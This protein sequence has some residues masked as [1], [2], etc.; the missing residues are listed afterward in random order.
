MKFLQTVACVLALDCVVVYLFENAF[1]AV[2][3]V[4]A[5]G[6]SSVALGWLAAAACFGV[7][8]VLLRFLRAGRVGVGKSAAPLLAFIVYFLIKLSVDAVDPDDIVSYTLSTSGGVIF[9]YLLGVIGAICMQGILELSP[10]HL[11]TRLFVNLGLFSFVCLFVVLLGVGYQDTASNLQ[12]AHLLVS[13][14]SGYQRSGNFLSMLFLLESLAVVG[15]VFINKRHGRLE[16]RIL[17]LSAIVAYV[18]T[19]PLIMYEGQLLGS[20]S[21]VLFVIATC[22]P[23]VAFVFFGLRGRDEEGKRMTLFKVAVIGI[24]AICALTLLAWGAVSYFDIDVTNLRL[25]NFGEGGAAPT[26]VSTRLAIL[27]S[28]YL[29]QLNYSPIF[30]NMAVDTLT[31]GTG[32]YAHSLPLSL[33]THLGI[34][35]FSLFVLFLWLRIRE[36]RRGDSWCGV[37]VGSMAR[38]KN[39]QLFILLILLAVILVAS[40]TTFFV[41]MPLWFALGLLVPPVA[42]FGQRNVNVPGA[43]SGLTDSRSP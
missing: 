4:A 19:V 9:S 7:I 41:W 27:Q 39:L 12:S 36:L 20:N 33:L 31:T 30:G 32:S 17:T 38:Q 6:V 37:T 35:G 14:T 21:V 3:S 1:S 26:S 18:V 29:R 23:S 22:V 8:S 24:A 28:D 13:D 15:M 34:T 2:G 16:S 11:L 25:F 40:L 43:V 42:F 5:V 10:K